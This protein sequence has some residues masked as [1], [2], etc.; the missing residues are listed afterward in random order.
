LA[1]LLFAAIFAAA[2]AQYY[3]A[4][5][6]YGYGYGYNTVGYTGAYAY[7]SYTAGAYG[8]GYPAYSGL[9]YYKK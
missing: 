5:P 1:V 3:A 6:G 9:A 2:T 4:Y 8:Y 7:P